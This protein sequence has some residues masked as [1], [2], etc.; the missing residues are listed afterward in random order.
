MYTLL[1]PSNDVFFLF[2]LELA[3][4]RR[5][6]AGD[7]GL[8][9]LWRTTPTVMIGR[10]QNLAEEVR[11]EEARARGVALVRRR[12]G[13]GTIYTDLG[14]WQFGFLTPARDDEP[15]FRRQLDLVTSSLREMGVPAE[16]SGRNDLTLCGRKISGSAGYRESGTL[17]HH[18]SLLFDSDLSAME[19]LTTVDPVKFRSKSIRSV[20]DRVTNIREHLPPRLSSMTA[21]EFAAALLRGILARAGD[22]G[23][24]PL[25]ESVLSAAKELGRNEFAS[26]A[27]L[28]GR[29][30]PFEVERVGHFPGGTLRARLSSRGG[31]LTGV[32]LAGDFFSSCDPGDWEAA[33]SGCPLERREILVRLRALP[34]IHGVSREG[35]AAL[36]CG[37]DS[38]KEACEPR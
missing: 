13:G 10:Y 31:V 36:L 22:D 18:G 32:T 23:A 7:T 17:V 20:R 27:A 5:G 33:L 11:A 1:P 37:E 3:L 21:D 30:P 29:N 38:P 8:L 28:L 6:A 15:P 4:A 35:L 2:G 19:R 12:S 9:M 16:L 34:P 26:R 14:G 25:S 24:L